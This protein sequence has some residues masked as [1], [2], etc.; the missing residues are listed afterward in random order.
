MTTSMKYYSVL[1][2]RSGAPVVKM[3]RQYHGYRITTFAPEPGGGTPGGMHDLVC[4]L[5]ARAEEEFLAS[6]GLGQ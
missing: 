2:M 4:R 3:V 5:N 6:N 1:P